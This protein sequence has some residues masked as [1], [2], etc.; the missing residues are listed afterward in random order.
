MKKYFLSVLL[1]GT[2]LLGTPA[3]SRADDEA[4]LVSLQRIE[5]NQQKI[6]HMLEDLKAELQIVKVRATHS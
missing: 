2:M 6:L 1:A 4:V 5:A 3:F